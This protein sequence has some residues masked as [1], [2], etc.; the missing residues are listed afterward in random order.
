MNRGLYK[1]V[2]CPVSENISRRG[3]YIPSGLAI[4]DEDINTVAETVKDVLNNCLQTTD[5]PPRK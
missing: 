2:S 1:N 3:F 4:S 5:P